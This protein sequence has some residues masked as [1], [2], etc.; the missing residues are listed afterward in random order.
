MQQTVAAL[1]TERAILVSSL[2]AAQTRS[3]T[4]PV[5][6]TPARAQAPASVAN[7]LA[8]RFGSLT[9]SGKVNVG[10]RN[11]RVVIELRDDA[12]FES[13][14]AELEASRQ[15]AVIELTR[16]LA[17]LDGVR[18][19][20]A[21]H[22]DD[23]PIRGWRFASNWALSVARALEVTKLMVE[24]GMDPKNV[25][26]A[27]YGERAPLAPNTTPEG[28]ARNRRIEIEVLPGTASN[29]PELTRAQATPPS[30]QN[31]WQ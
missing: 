2:H 30:L 23:V 29:T 17:S 9:Q 15:G 18:F 12:L 16:V 25:S 19:V 8:L 22:T 13:G 11:D 27:G 4:P 31:D 26:A 14:R 7:D 5:P 6:C 20:V 21:G 28:R 1:T 3:A 10:V 24:N